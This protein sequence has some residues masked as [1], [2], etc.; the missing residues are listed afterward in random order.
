VGFIGSGGGWGVPS[1]IELSLA[2]KDVKDSQK[3]SLTW[4]S[5]T[6]TMRVNHC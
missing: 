1:H 2:V 6:L 4:E 3:K 5:Y